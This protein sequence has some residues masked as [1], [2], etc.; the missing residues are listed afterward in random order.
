MERRK[1]NRKIFASYLALLLTF[2]AIMA[3][4]LASSS[5]DNSSTPSTIV[6]YP[7]DD[8]TIE[9][10]HPDATPGS[11]EFLAIRND[12]GE[13]GSS[14]WEWSALIKFDLSSIPPGTTIESAELRLYYHHWWD[15]DPGG[16]ELKLYRII[17]DWDESTTNW[18]NFPGTVSEA[19]SSS[20]VPY[21]TNTWVVW[22]VTEDVQKFINGEFPNYGWKIADE[23]YWGDIN[24]PITYLCSKEYND[25]EYIPRLVI[26][27]VVGNKP[28]VADFTWMP[29][30]PGPNEEVTFDASD[31]YD[32]DGMIVSYEW[33]WDNDGAYDEI[34]D[35][36]IATHS[37]SSQGDYLVSLR[38]TDNN[39]AT[40]TTTKSIHIG[41]FDISW[42]YPSP[43]FLWPQ[44]YQHYGIHMDV[45][46]YADTGKTFRYGLAYTC[47]PLNLYG[48]E[49]QPDWSL[50]EESSCMVRITSNT[51]NFSYKYTWGTTTTQ[52]ISGGG[53]CK[54]VFRVSS[55]WNW[56]QPWSTN[57]V[58]KII[59]N[60]GL[61]AL[62]TYLP[63]L[64]A[65]IQQWNWLDLYNTLSEIVNAVWQMKYKYNGLGDSSPNSEGSVIVW[66]PPSKAVALVDSVASG[67]LGSSATTAGMAALLFPI[68][69]WEIAAA[70][71]CLQGASLLHSE[72]SYLTAADPHENYTEISYPKPAYIPA[73]DEIPEGPEKDLSR[74]AL[75]LLSY[76]EA[77]SESMRKYYGAIYSFS[78]KWSTIQLSV[79]QYYNKKMLSTAQKLRSQLEDIIQKIPQLDDEEIQL[80]REN[81]TENG[82]PPFEEKV[83]RQLGYSEE[84]IE[85][86]LSFYI[87]AD[88]Y[89]YK[90]CTELLE[91]SLDLLITSIE[92][93]QNITRPSVNSSIYFITANITTEP[94]LI[95]VTE[96]PQSIKC[97]IEF[98]N[99][100]N[101]TGYRILSAYLNGKVSP[102]HIYASPADVDGDGKLEFIVRYDASDIIP[103]IQRNG[104]FLISIFGNV[105]LPSGD[106]L[107]YSGATLLKVEGITTFHIVK[108]KNALYINDE[109]IISLPVTV[110][111]GSITI[112]TESTIHMKRVEFYVDGQLK[113]N[114]T[115]EPY[116][117]TWEE[118]AFG[119]HT[120]TMV[121]Y[122]DR[123]I[124]YSD[125]I[126]VWKFF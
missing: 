4:P 83:L 24:I 87:S 44:M 33:D 79:A 109:E 51:D 70:L 69:G 117:W 11:N 106:I 94:S 18:N 14:G 38:V 36:P 114:I 119:K 17:D 124:R 92:A 112:E 95:D 77:W 2:S 91:N 16:R 50:D 9:A 100:S 52:Y 53:W 45:S 76:S 31:S 65:D 7:S 108:P 115:S 55:R 75:E 86:I 63:E 113:A 58:L 118:K 27:V 116:I 68:G 107:T 3:S 1:L 40:D 35:N 54:G 57:R 47:T 111:V 126:V 10:N 13:G 97:Y 85:E 42:D 72:T 37:W 122:D 88:D 32:P 6:I 105:S 59:A 26:T 71:F 23:N 56:I 60:I 62:S 102:S 123:E 43:G 5:T 78:R 84:E 103:L 21:S 93:M 90:N 67:M 73:L 12:Y 41:Y 74:T 120:I 29:E 121:A 81:L 22:D 15:N 20:I 104:E 61:S 28:P 64:T 101:V 66:I 110:I 30:H 89:L 46:N 25:D 34:H 39:G 98:E 99:I 82:L 96:S 49:A 19:S 48:E 80:L 125:E 8:T